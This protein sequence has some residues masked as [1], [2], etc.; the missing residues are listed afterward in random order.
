MASPLTGSDGGD[1]SQAAPLLDQI[2]ATI[3]SVPADGA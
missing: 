3:S 2:E 1:P